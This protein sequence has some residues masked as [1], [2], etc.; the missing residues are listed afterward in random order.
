MSSA[1]SSDGGRINSMGAGT[2][3]KGPT[4][5]ARN[6]TRARP[7]DE[8]TCAGELKDGRKNVRSENVCKLQADE[9]Q[10]TQNEVST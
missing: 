7:K 1:T 8:D 3:D 9:E 2:V 4:I 6:S 10:G 5:V